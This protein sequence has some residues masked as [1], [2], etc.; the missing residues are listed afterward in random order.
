MTTFTAPAKTWRREPVATCAQTVRAATMPNGT[1][2]MVR[3]YRLNGPL[4]RGESVR[5]IH[6]ANRT[7]TAVATVTMLRLCSR[8]LP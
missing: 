4:G 1:S 3:S 7:H 2:A 5:S 6:P 8:W